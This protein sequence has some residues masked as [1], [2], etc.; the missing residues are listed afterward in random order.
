MTLDLGKL[1][2]RVPDKYAADIL[3]KAKMQNCNPCLTPVDTKAKPSASSGTP[4]SDTTH[5]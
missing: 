5:Y 2:R 3:K 1:S 4:L